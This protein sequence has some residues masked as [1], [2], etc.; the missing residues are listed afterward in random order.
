MPALRRAA[1]L[2]ACLGIPCALP[3]SA[4]WPLHFESLPVGPALAHVNGLVFAPDGTALLLEKPGLVRVMRD[5]VLQSAPLV[6]LR[7]EVNNDWDRGLLGLAL[8]PG[9]VPNGTDSAW[10]YLLYTVA[11]VFGQD[12]AYN[13]N[14]Q[15]SFSRLTRY[16]VVTQGSD[17]VVDAG[18]RQILLGH[19][20]ADG[21]VPDG[22]A[23]LHNSHSNGSLWFGSDGTLLI[24]T[25]DGAHYD[26]TDTGGF[27]NPGFDDW[28]HP[29]TGKLGPTP[30]LQDSG[31]F[32]SQ[33]LR[34]LAGKILRVD[35]TTGLGL[36]SNPFWDGN[37]AGLP[38]RVWALGLRNPFRGTPLPGSGSSD[39][40]AGDPG[41]AIVG[42]V[43]WNVW[44]ELDFVRRG[45]NFGWP[46]R[47]GF[48]TLG[49]YQAFQPPN[50][51]FPICSTTPA[52]TLR[53]PLL[54]WHHTNAGALAPA[55]LH[56][57]ADGNPLNGFAGNCAIG[58][59]FPGPG[60]YPSA[61]AGR[62]FFGDYTRKFIRTLAFDAVS[63]LAQGVYDFGTTSAG[64]V[65][66]ETHPLTGE[67][68]YVELAGQSAQVRRIRYG[69]NLTPI[70]LASVTPSSGPLPLQIACD[71]SASFD[72]DQDPLSYAWDFGDGS[73]L[74]TTP[75]AAHTYANAG[76]YAVRLDV[77][78]TLGA[79]G[80]WTQMVYA[81][82][83]P[84]QIAISS[85][86]QGT[87][88][89][90]PLVLTLTG[91]ALDPE[92][93][94]LALNW[95]IDLLHGDHLHPG[96]FTS[97]DAQ[98]NFTIDSHGEPGESYAYRVRLSA[99]DSQGLAQSASAWLYP[100]ANLL[101]PSGT[102]Q[103]IT[104][105][106]QLSPPVAQ[107]LGNKD[108]EVFR[109]LIE[110]AV[111]S[112]ANDKQ[113]DSAHGGDQ[114]QD[115]WV[116]LAAYVALDR[117]SAFVGLRFQEGRHYADGGWFEALWV[118][119]REN[120]E[121]R[122]AENLRITPD[123][124]FALAQQSGFDGVGYQTYELWFDPLHGD[125]IRLRGTPGGSTGYVS[126]AELRARL[127]SP[128]PDPGKHR[129]ISAAAT[130]VAH[131]FG[132]TPPNPTGSGSKDP[133]TIRNG[134]RPQLGSTSAL[135]QYDTQHL[136]KWSGADWIGYTWSAPRLLSR[137]EYLE[138]LTFTSG[139]GW[140]S[141]RVETQ[142]GNGIWTLLLG[143]VAQP[144][145]PPQVGPHYE[146]VSFEFAPRF[147]HG[148]RLNGD[149]HG[150]LNYISVGE[151]RAFEVQQPAPCAAASYGA[152]S[153]AAAL[154]L[155]ALSDTALGL[156]IGLQ[157]S[158]A[159]GAGPGLLLT[160]SAQ[161]SLALL[162]V[163]LLVDP[164]GWVALPLSFDASG[165][166]QAFGQL[167]G[168]PLLAGSKLY[169]QAAR[170]GAAFPGSVEL[171][172]GLALTLCGW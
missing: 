91:S 112:T 18:S 85:P 38:S 57:D 152:G 6:D 147:A 68:W 82:N 131:I 111:G 167:G 31:A 23:S 59:A 172:N 119:V 122:K 19:Q 30:A 158:G 132:L 69:A 142:D 115:D 117:E 20:F 106:Q 162:G 58:G 9:F 64:V 118:E 83:A 100:S 86:L 126:C 52:G 17:W 37:A 77:T 43:G 34:S 90:A 8:Q 129:D 80:S 144:G 73:P 127:L 75:L 169:F 27:D 160:G 157:V 154:Q 116:G 171:S 39:P 103:P 33:D 62:L 165:R 44:E 7:D 48:A 105:V 96:V 60:A 166:A 150:S 128:L 28:L 141:L 139:G 92:D 137:L 50:P 40:S 1:A 74:A 5:G 61:Y 145:L 25:G 98:P 89:E 2:I 136:P 51:A 163:T 10:A 95:S 76:A 143:A 72:T 168:D 121:W 54:A 102:M 113:F 47:E 161:A 130:I 125:A 29:Q 120:G 99:T 24:A 45:D 15:Y 42:D 70:A 135:A 46:C 67:V 170:F 63:G 66:L 104:R 87:L 84:P 49:S 134:T 109:D 114:G 21:S 55:G 164:A 3:A 36:P 11:P 149:P 124:P 107:G 12:S 156:P 65:D 138:G 93:G 88:F 101:D 53:D 79:T 78:D 56:F 97:S 71:G 26:L 133:E 155:S 148:I 94:P 110:P 35:P 13:Q 159:G 22:I 151:L 4:Q 146:S 153:G 41:L 32:R 140:N 123:Y 108:P 16:R 81:G 14:Q